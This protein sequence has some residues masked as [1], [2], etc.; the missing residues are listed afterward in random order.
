MID[1]IDSVPEN[2]SVGV[3]IIL[4]DKFTNEIYLSKR[5]SEYEN[6]KYAC[7]GGL[8]EV[9]ETWKDAMIRELKEETG[10]S[11]SSKDIKQIAIARHIGSKSNYTVWYKYYCNANDIPKNC[12]PTKHEEWCAYTK[13]DALKLPLMLSTKETIEQFT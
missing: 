9:N 10:M 7:P 11:I 13:K 8:V 1:Y 2:E 12:E 5:L 4:F 3:C 6:G